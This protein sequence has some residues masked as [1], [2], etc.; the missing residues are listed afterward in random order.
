MVQSLPSL[1]TTPQGVALI[2]IAVAAILIFVPWVLDR[3][4]SN[5][6]EPV[7]SEPTESLLSVG[8]EDGPA[9]LS[10]L[11]RSPADEQPT[12]NESDLD[13]APADGPMSP[14][15]E[16]PTERIADHHQNATASNDVRHQMGSITTDDTHRKVLFAEP[17]DVADFLA[18]G[19]LHDV[20]G[21]PDLQYDLSIHVRPMDRQDAEKNAQDRLDQLKSVSST[22]FDPEGDETRRQETAEEMQRLRTYSSSIGSGERPA[23]VTI[24]VGARGEDERELE[25]QAKALK[26][27]MWRNPADMGLETAVGVQDQA[28]QSL[29]PIGSDPLGEYDRF[30]VELLGSGVGALLAS[31]NRS[32]V[33]E[34]GGVEWGEHAYNG[35]PILKD[36][37]KSEKNYN[38][39][40]LADSGG[41]KSYNAKRIMLQ[42]WEQSTDTLLIMLDPVEGF[43]GLAEA[44]GAKTITIGGDR[45]LNIMEIRE[46]PEDIEQSDRDPFGSKMNEFLGVIENY[47]NLENQPFNEERNTLEQAAREAYKRVDGFE[48]DDPST[49][50]AGNPTVGDELLDVLD[51]MH[52]NPGEYAV[53]DDGR[54]AETIKSHT[55]HLATILQPFAEGGRLENLGQ[56]S[57]FDIRDTDALYLDLSQK[58]AVGGT[59][60]MM[61]IVWSMIYERAKETPKNVI[62]GIDEAEKLM[63][64]S[65]NMQWLEDR[66]RR[67]RHL[68]MST[69]FITQ[70]VADFFKH[71]RAEVL[72]N[73]SHF[74]IYHST[75]EIDEYLDRLDLSDQHAK[76]IKDANTGGSG[77]DDAGGE[78]EYSNALY[79]FG[80]R[81]VPAKIESLDAEHKVIDFDPDTDS[82]ADLPGYGGR[83]SVLAN[84]IE[85]RLEQGN[86]QGTHV[87]DDGG[88]P[89]PGPWPGAEEGLTEAQHALL[90][91]LTPTELEELQTRINRPNTDPETEIKRAVLAKTEELRGVLDLDDD[92][93]NRVLD[94]LGNGHLARQVSEGEG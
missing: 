77:D 51:E 6:S 37:F 45:G 40:W 11:E 2:L 48:I 5:E 56:E 30:T 53:F 1:L 39:T 89:A 9:G 24:T 20:L 44:I 61:Q 82:K 8:S 72:L 73:N 65:T 46:P 57:D 52:A 63:K 12:F 94:I 3:R 84:E 34:E 54:G 85:R 74:R 22:M 67:A 19:A 86:H 31:W 68:D 47:A 92:P 79:Q 81:F 90:D 64:Q 15:Y 70:D 87:V 14:R 25:K 75:S 43:R 18:P 55:E 83:D 32:T 26:N 49:W 10:P 4:R 29:S 33:I 36:P 69:W 28:I 58:D 42:C 62:L 66:V 41:G 59:S 80:D 50:G 21:N 76:F 78:G 35:S 38:Q 17:D 27:T 88:D 60:L 91:L 7:V 23:D 13:T 71:D 93:T 16:T